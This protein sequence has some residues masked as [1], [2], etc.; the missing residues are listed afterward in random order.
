MMMALEATAKHVGLSKVMLTVFKTNTNAMD[1]YLRKMGYT[2]DPSSP[3]LCGQ[4][5]Q[6]EILSKL[7]P[8]DT[9]A[10]LQQHQA[11]AHSTAAS[12]PSPVPAAD[13]A[14]DVDAPV[15][16]AQGEAATPTKSKPGEVPKTS[17]D[18]VASPAVTA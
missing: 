12:S 7:V 9:L 8:D 14:T 1:F 18:G 15:P 4:K 5:A 11:Q 3:S 16:A 6:Y 10:R 13:V 2:I 17:P